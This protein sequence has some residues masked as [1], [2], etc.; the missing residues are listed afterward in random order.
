VSPAA[1]SGRVIG[2]P[3]GISSK[4]FLIQ[5]FV[6]SGLKSPDTTSVVLFGA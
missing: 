5:P 1:P 4:Y 2:W 3:L 6:F